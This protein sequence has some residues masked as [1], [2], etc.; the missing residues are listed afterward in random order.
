MTSNLVVP[1]QPFPSI[2][3]ELRVEL[4]DIYQ[5][6]DSPNFTG[7]WGKLY[8]SHPA[9]ITSLEEESSLE[10][11]S[12]TRSIRR[13]VLVGFDPFI[14]AEHDFIVLQV[15]SKERRRVSSKFQLLE[16]KESA[17]SQL[18]PEQIN[19]FS[20]VVWYDTRECTL[21]VNKK[22]FGWLAD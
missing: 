3:S 18:S 6:L 10:R 8:V 21:V 7:T 19:S 14:F 16:G 5:R 13:S 15:F 12:D 9:I 11:R 20:S 22:L 1:G 4:A 2:T 17:W